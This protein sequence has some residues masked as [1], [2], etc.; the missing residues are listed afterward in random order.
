VISFTGTFPT[1][2][3]NWWAASKNEIAQQ[4]LNDNQEAWAREVDPQENSAWSPL[5]PA[6]SAWKQRKYPNQPILRASGQMFDRTRIRPETSPGIFRAKMGAE[7]G[8]YHMTGTSKM[9][10]RPW[11]GI[12]QSSMPGISLAVINAINR[13]KD[14]RF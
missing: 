5:K 4:L 13:G 11:L 9:G 10:A 12:P 7:Y 8:K 1:F 6:Y 2:N 3:T 14:R